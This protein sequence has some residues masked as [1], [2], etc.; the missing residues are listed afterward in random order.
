MNVQARLEANAILDRLVADGQTFARHD[1]RRLFEL[2]PPT[3]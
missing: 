1:A 3:T 2:I